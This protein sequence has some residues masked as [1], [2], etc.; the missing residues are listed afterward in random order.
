MKPKSPVNV[1]INPHEGTSTQIV[2][3]PVQSCPSNLTNNNSSLR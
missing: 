1:S 3:L 2:S